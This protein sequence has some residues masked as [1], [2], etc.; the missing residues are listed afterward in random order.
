MNSVELL[1]QA[2]S[3]AKK[4]KPVFYWGSHCQFTWYET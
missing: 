3:L 4:Y 1:I 2:G